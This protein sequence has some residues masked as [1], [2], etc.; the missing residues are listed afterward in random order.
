MK[1]VQNP[2]S[3]EPGEELPYLDQSQKIKDALSL[4]QSKYLDSINPS[5]A[6]DLVLSTYLAYLDPYSEYIP[7]DR[8]SQYTKQINGKGSGIGFTLIHIDTTYLISKIES[9][10]PAYI[11]GLRVGD[12]LL[13]IDSLRL[14]TLVFNTD[15]LLN[16][17]AEN[18]NQ[19]VQLTWKSLET[20]E[21]QDQIIQKAE[22]NKSPVCC[23]HSPIPGVLYVKLEQLSKDSYRL[24]MRTL[25]QYFETRH[26]KHLIVDLRDNSGGLVH[27]A[28]FI[29]NQLIEE[30]N[31]LMFKTAGGK[32]KEKEYRSTGKPFFEIEKIVILVN[33]HTAS[34]AELIAASL[35]DLDRAV[36]IGEP[37]LGKSTVLEQFSLGDGSAIRLSVSRFITYSGRSIQKNYPSDSSFEYLAKPHWNP[38]SEFYSLKKNK[39]SSHQGV[40]PDIHAQSSGLPLE[41]LKLYQNQADYFIGRN[42]K[43]LKKLIDDQADRILNDRRVNL[44]INTE[45]L[46]LYPSKKQMASYQSAEMEFRYA[47][48]RWFFSEDLE[49]RMR[50][51]KDEVLQTGMEVLTK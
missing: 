1:Q 14:D 4:I 29:L 3:R 18:P 5:E 49:K 22:W 38:T 24:F 47:L 27:E 28:A 41:E 19:H 31:R 6:T 12:Q 46:R 2:I 9:K 15:S 42:Y 45:L 35:Q 40:I 44:M 26:Y 25:E 39:L 20:Q 43:N 51:E 32:V 16:E 8:M 23:A 48:A 7:V 17:I 37:T 36:I 30:K 11:A 13:K 21:T 34:A 33:Q 50:L 10:S